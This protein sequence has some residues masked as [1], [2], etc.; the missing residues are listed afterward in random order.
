L[1]TAE[2]KGEQEERKRLFDVHAAQFTAN[3]ATVLLIRYD[4]RNLNARL[5]R[6]LLISRGL[7]FN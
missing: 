1:A 7:I 5:G 4:L 2:E 3:R 6:K